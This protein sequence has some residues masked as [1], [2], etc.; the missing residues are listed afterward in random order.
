MNILCT[1]CEW[2]RRYVVDEWKMRERKRPNEDQNIWIIWCSTV[3]GFLCDCY[4][5]AFTQAKAHSTR[6]SMRQSV[7]MCVCSDSCAYI[8]VEWNTN[9]YTRTRNTRVGIRCRMCTWVFHAWIRLCCSAVD[10]I[11]ET[12]TSFVY[13][14]DI[15]AAFLLL[16]PTL[17]HSNQHYQIH[18]RRI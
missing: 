15:V 14:G 11:R 8:A 6:T 18:E 5:E 16:R 10:Y 9:T 4:S 3:N 1:K 2:K 13:I 17:W 12:S 7:C